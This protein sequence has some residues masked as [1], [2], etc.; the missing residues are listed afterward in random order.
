MIDFSTIFG[1]KLEEP[2]ANFGCWQAYPVEPDVVS[3][4][5]PW[6][7]AE[8]YPEHDSSITGR[9]FEPDYTFGSREIE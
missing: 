2:D 4:P 3:E 8:A 7:G 9:E 6:H 1:R 5:L